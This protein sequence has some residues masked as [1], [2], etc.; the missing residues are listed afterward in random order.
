MK[1]STEI[2]NKRRSIKEDFIN[3][4][5][6]NQRSNN[7]RPFSNTSNRIIKKNNLKLAFA[8]E[9]TGFFNKKFDLTLYKK[10]RENSRAQSK[11]QKKIILHQKRGNGIPNNII[12]RITFLGKKFN[13]PKLVKYYN[14]RPEKKDYSFEETI[15][16]IVNYSK[17]HS[18]LDSAML[19]Y[20]FVC[21]EI[22]FDKECYDNDQENKF[23]QK[24]ETVFDEGMAISSGF[25][26]LFEYIL[27]KMEIKYK[28]IDGY[29]KLMPKKNKKKLK[30]RKQRVLS[31]N[32]LND[33]MI[34]LN[35]TINHS[36]D[37][38][39][40][41]GEWY[42]CDCLF[43]SGSIEPEEDDISKLNLKQLD[44]NNNLYNYNN[45]IT[46]NTKSSEP[47]DTFNFYY[48][49]VPP[50][51]L[52]STHRPNDDEW[53]FIYKTLSFKQFFNK[54]LINYGE[55]YMNAY[56]FNVKLL[57]H[58]NPFIL[59][60][61]NEKLIIKI[62][63]SGYLIE[64]N[65]F[66]SY[67]NTKIAEVKYLYEESTDSY[68]LEPI[69]PQKGE[70]ILKINA[71]SIKSTDLL[72]MPLI[73]YIIKVDTYFQI[74]NI[75]N[76]LPLKESQIKEKDKVEEIL[77]K[78]IRSSSIGIFTPKII[79]DYSKIFP[80]KTVKKICYDNE[81]FRL[82]EPRSNYLKRGATIRFKIFV[83]G[84]VN[85]S[86]LDGN[87]LTSLKRFED[88]LFIGQKEI[89]TNNVSLCCLR[90]KNV[91]TE[92]YKFKVIKE[93][94]IMSSKPILSRKKNI[95]FK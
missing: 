73:D 12:D 88:G 59:I 49:M 92:I 28:H 83:K 10:N 69:F 65:L 22:K 77:P 79:S 6:L 52:I 95:L 50:E 8:K 74:S 5:I 67:G 34:L 70:Y 60:T 72:Y 17:K 7:A 63:I 53:Q 26:N 36:W 94:R 37:A 19:A 91:F 71:R 58:K 11:S 46:N 54:R 62:K 90:S 41:R 48:F 81:N 78:L 64:A 87:H 39:F 29:C 2:L 21:K 25:T 18:K 85:V 42:F 4:K 9:F 3:T 32:N 57:T 20:Y 31:A 14:K 13:E 51:L 66:Y 56:K 80:P 16:Y 35:Q 47:I 55:F 75:N 43:G 24:P 82:I 45:N 84:A 40:I 89:E 27:R 15:E 33:D 76:L 23:N 86:I 1:D 38:I 44:I 93:G 30:S 68:S 61:T